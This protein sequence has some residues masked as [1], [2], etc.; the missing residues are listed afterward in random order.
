MSHGMKK[1]LCL[2]IVTAL[3]ALAAAGCREKRPLPY[4]P[5]QGPGDDESS[6]NAAPQPPTIT[7][8][9]DP[10][11]VAYGS[12]LTLIWETTGA[13][14]VTIE[15]VGKFPPQGSAVIKPGA[16]ADYRAIARGAGGETEAVVH[17]EVTGAPSAD[18]ALSGRDGAAGAVDEKTLE[19][20]IAQIFRTEVKDVFFDFDRADLREEDRETLKGNA[21][22][23]LEKIPN[24]RVVIE[25]HCDERGSEEYN[26]ALGDRRA[27]VVRDYLLS[28]G[29]PAER[30]KTIS[31][32]KERPLDPAQTEEAFAKNRRAHFMLGKF[33]E[34][35]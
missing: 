13:D 32:G 35:K 12:H 28:L 33:K 34:D 18:G 19:E 3:L 24:A 25:G 27:T 17:V 23:F 2:G 4:P 16:T 20:Q 5:G 7:F 31:F 11:T 9:A 30:V 6:R 14:D 26:L 21:K 22:V 15:D 1:M 10:A 8:R 29:V